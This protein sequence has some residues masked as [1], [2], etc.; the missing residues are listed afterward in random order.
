MLMMLELRLCGS[1]LMRGNTALPTSLTLT[2]LTSRDQLQW[3]PMMHA[4][5]AMT[6]REYR[7]CS[8]VS[9][10]RTLSKLEALESDS[11]LCTISLVSQLIFDFSN[12]MCM[13]SQIRQPCRVLGIIQLWL[14]FN[15]RGVLIFNLA[16]T[17]NNYV[18]QLACLVSSR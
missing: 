16:S 11:T 4:S 18:T 2:W 13:L 12:S 1:M 7:A 3:L 5:Q 17:Y 9:R 10:P 8:R 14:F 15:F 6:G